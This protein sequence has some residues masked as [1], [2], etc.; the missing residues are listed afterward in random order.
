[1]ACAAAA[2]A[3]VAA[4]AAAAAAARLL[5]LD[6]GFPRRLLVKRALLPERGLRL[7]CV[8][9][10]LRALRALLELRAEGG[11]RSG[12]GA[13]TLIVEAPAV[14]D[15]DCC[16]ILIAGLGGRPCSELGVLATPKCRC[17]G[18]RG[19]AGNDV[20][21]VRR[22]EAGN[23]PVR[24]DA[25]ASVTAADRDLLALFDAE[26]ARF[27]RAAAFTMLAARWNLAR[28][29]FVLCF[30]NT[31]TRCTYFS[32]RRGLAVLSYSTRSPSSLR[33]IR[34]EEPPALESAD[35]E[36]RQ[37]PTEVSTVGFKDD[38]KSAA[39]IVD[40]LQ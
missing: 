5:F 14:D 1:M 20:W 25:V 15:K 29:G 28:A 33:T 12:E 8:L 36:S 4:A 31:S 30:G 38:K 39:A 35:F 17:G 13:P 21:G 11:L 2:D 22:G 27:T 7:V 40:A 26:L 10:V 18:C 23:E 3:A 37:G 34:G 19:S 24:G 16:P 6:L 9:V 32:T